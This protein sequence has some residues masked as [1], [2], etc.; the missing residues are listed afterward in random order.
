MSQE[1]FGASV[2]DM[3]PTHDAQLLA[4]SERLLDLLRAFLEVLYRL[5][6]SLG[7]LVRTQIGLAFPLEYVAIEGVQ[8]LLEVRDEG[9]G[10]RAYRVKQ[11]E[12]VLVHLRG[13]GRTICHS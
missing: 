8:H 6:D 9:L 5:A 11:V 2:F 10:V 13:H 4:P 7:T 1:A 3:I 12:Q